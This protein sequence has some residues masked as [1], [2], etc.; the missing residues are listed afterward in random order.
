MFV[1]DYYAAIKHATETIVNFD[2]RI[3]RLEKNS[4]NSN[5]LSSLIPVLT[6]LLNIFLLE[7]FISLF[8]PQVYT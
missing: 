8:R 7:N 6:F 3:A 5:F 2:E 1:L 4:S